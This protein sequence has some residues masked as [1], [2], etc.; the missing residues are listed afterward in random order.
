M[1]GTISEEDIQ[2]VREAN[3][4]VAL[5]GERTPVQQRGHDFWCCCPFHGEKTPSFKIDPVLQLWHCFGCGEGGDIFG[6]VMKS[7]DLTFPEAVRRLAERAH[8]DIVETGGKGTVASSYKARLRAVCAETADFYHLQLMRSAAQPAGA[9][10]SYLTARGFGGEV[11][12]TWHLGFAPGSGALV[13]HL[14]A[15]GFKS[16]EM[17]DAN[18]AV[19]NEGGRLKDRFFNRIMFPI[20][21]PQGEYIAFGGRVIGDGQPKYLNS[22][23]TPLFHKSQVLYGLDRAKAAMAATGIA[24]VVEGYTDVIAL[25]EAGI[26]HAVATLG[27]A[28]T[29]RHIRL[30]SRHAQHRIVYLFDGDEAGQRAADRALAFIDDSMTPEAGRSKIEL[31]AVTLPDNLDPAEFVEARGA[32]ALRALIA[33][34][35]PLLEYGIERRIA[36]YDLTRAEGRSMALADALSVLVPIRDSLLA[37]DYAV[38][39]AGRVHAREQDAID[40]LARMTPPRA[41]RVQTESAQPAEPV[42]RE[43]NLPQAEL[44]RRRFEREFLSLMAQRPDLGLAHVDALAQTQWHEQAHAL[45]AQSMLDTLAEKPDASPVRVITDA[46]NVLPAAASILTSGS[47]ADE[48]APGPLASFLVEELAI[49]D[50][51]EAVVALRAQLAQP[52]N[53]SPED[54][55]MLFETVAAMQKDLNCRRM[56]HK[57]LAPR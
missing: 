23:E 24:V 22:Q 6:F 20:R 52:A 34:A 10:R 40:Q 30:L 21:D 19:Q 5:I 17:V 2:K 44:N 41:D 18:V 27:T 42:V 7:E 8:I 28:L 45:V 35:Q 46:Q 53:L 57:P 55:E 12:K 4:L 37:K 31:A 38:Q 13:R 9:A 32:D 16:Q 11:P 29:L 14:T 43:E 1:A 39:I 3:D 25:H 26:T 56:A 49:G 33:D 51:E 48:T 36:R 54:Y 15:K 47:M 50:I